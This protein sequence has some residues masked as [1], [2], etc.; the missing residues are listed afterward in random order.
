MSTTTR[1]EFVGQCAGAAAGAWLLPSFA[2]A[3][4]SGPSVKFPS[5]PRERVAVAAY[6]FREFIVGWKGWDGK[7]PSTVPLAQ[8]ME[9]KDF[10]AHVAAKFNVHH[11]EPW[12]PIFPSTD[13]KYLEQFR[14]AVEKAKSTVVDIAVDGRHSQYAVDAAERKASV[15]ATN[16]WIDVAVAL[17]SPSIRTHIDGGKELKPDVSLAADTLARSAEYGAKKN[18]VVD[19]ENDNPVSED[20]FFIV[21]VIEKV[22]SPWLRAL[23]D[24]GNSLAAHDEAFQDRAMEAMFAHAYGICHV[25]DGEVD[26]GK[27]SHVDLAKTFGILKK[28]EYKGYCSIEYDAPGDPYKPTAALVEATIKYLS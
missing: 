20:P 10:A 1:R 27:V 7:T 28:H 8:Q 16:Q 9:L 6:P 15:T 4:N 24:F 11:I 3:A 25:K 19:L 17:G 22:N 5:D 2:R 26:D 13:P 21:Q 18:V 12:S 14:A 23:P